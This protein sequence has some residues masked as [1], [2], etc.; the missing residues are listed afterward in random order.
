MDSFDIIL[1]SLLFISSVIIQKIAGSINNNGSNAKYLL[2]FINT[3]SYTC[4]STTNIWFDHLLTVSQL[5]FVHFRSGSIVN[6]TACTLYEL[7]GLGENVPIGSRTQI[8]PFVPRIQPTLHSKFRKCS[9]CRFTKIGGTTTR[10]P[11]V[12]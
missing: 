6:I 2:E 7:D 5:L 12:N 3:G 10:T 1:H 9:F 4:Y 11:F 8:Y